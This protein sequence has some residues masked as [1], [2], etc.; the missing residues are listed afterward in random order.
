MFFVYRTCLSMYFLYY[1]DLWMINATKNPRALKLHLKWH[2]QKCIVW[3]VIKIHQFIQLT[4]FL[5]SSLN[6]SGPLLS[7][8]GCGQ[9][10]S[11]WDLQALVKIQ[12]CRSQWREGL[13]VGIHTGHQHCQSLLPGRRWQQRHSTGS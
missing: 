11:T 8:R 4:C 6:M 13:V 5:S 3:T 9:Q 10:V 7:I 2:T 12:L 1:W